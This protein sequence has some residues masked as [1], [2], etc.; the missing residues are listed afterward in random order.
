MTRSVTYDL[1]AGTFAMNGRH[2]SHV[3][4]LDLL[5]GAIAFYEKMAR[6]YRRELYADWAKMLREV[7][8]EIA[9]TS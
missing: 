8:S 2:W 3:Y 7:R 5:D 1:D 6:D 4:R 9:A